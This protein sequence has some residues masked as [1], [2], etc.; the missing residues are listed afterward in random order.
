MST[1]AR[2]VEIDQ[3]A[4][5]RQLADLFSALSDALDEF[6]LADHDPP[7]PPDELTRVKAKAQELEDLSHRFTAEAIGATLQSIQPNLAHLKEITAQA[8]SQVGVLE[9]V[10]K[11]ISI[12]SSA[13]SLGTAIAAGDPGGIVTAAEGLAES[14]G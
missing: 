14:F 9:E 2:F 3:A 4:E 11:V 13:L 6:R 12:A 10:S 5:A 1:P 8:Q 7:L